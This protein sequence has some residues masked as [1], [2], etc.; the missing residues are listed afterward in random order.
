MS[1][2]IRVFAAM[3]GGAATTAVV[4]AVVH[5]L[6]EYDF[7]GLFVFAACTAVAFLAGRRVNAAQR[8]YLALPAPT[9]SDF[10]LVVSP[11]GK[12]QRRQ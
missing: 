6:T 11:Q 1:A 3:C 7:H 12:L 2:R 10:A 4:L 5:W 8:A 9:P